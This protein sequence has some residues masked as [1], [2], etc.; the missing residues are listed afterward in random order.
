MAVKNL[1]HVKIVYVRLSWRLK[2]WELC[3]FGV[4]FE[5]IV[6]RLTSEKGNEE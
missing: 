5:C 2:I 1:A 6:I 3:Q 4:A